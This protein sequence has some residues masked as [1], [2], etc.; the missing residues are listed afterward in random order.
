VGN[1]A[2]EPV[3]ICIYGSLKLLWT[4]QTRGTRVQILLGAE[5][6]IVVVIY[7]HV[8]VEAVR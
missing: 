8:R 7:D 2:A 4:V 6:Y 1:K 3:D 5:I